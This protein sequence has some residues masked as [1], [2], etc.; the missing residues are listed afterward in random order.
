MRFLVP[1]LVVGALVV[2]GWVHEVWPGSEAQ[3]VHAVR[4]AFA[5]ARA[6]GAKA[7]CSTTRHPVVLAADP[8]SGS[9]SAMMSGHM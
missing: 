9:S 3:V 1:V 4:V 6:P 8:N 5:D 2:G 7:H